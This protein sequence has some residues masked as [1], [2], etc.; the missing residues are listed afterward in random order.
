MALC[1]ASLAFLFGLI[2]GSFLNVCIL[3]IPAGESIV[4]PGS[5]C[6]RCH[7]AIAFYDN[8]PVL[9]WLL[10]GGKC[11]NCKAKIS[12]MYPAIELL[13]GRALLSLLPLLWRDSCRGQVG[14]FLSA[15]LSC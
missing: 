10:L 7:K 14:D 6:P 12:P 11:R 5:R 4:R 1:Q 9:S 2:I 13:T 15:R 8:I 3:R